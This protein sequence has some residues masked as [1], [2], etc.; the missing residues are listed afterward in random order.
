[1]STSLTALTMNPY[2]PDQPQV[3]IESQQRCLKSMSNMKFN[4]AQA[5]AERKQT[6]NLLV[7]SVNRFISF[8]I[9]AREGKF[10]QANKILGKRF[11]LLG[12]K[13]PRF[14]KDTFRKP[15]RDDFANLWLEYSYGWRP[16]AGDIHGAAELLAQTYSVEF[17]RP[18]RS[19]GTSRAESAWTT[20]HDD[21]GLTG[22]GRLKASVTA[23]TVIYYDVESQVA[24]VLK[25][26]GISNPALLA[27]E[28]LPY[29][30][31]LDWFI[32][33]GSYLEACNASAGLRFIKGSTSTLGKGS[34]LASSV[35]DNSQ[36]ILH[37]G[38]PAWLEWAELT[39]ERLTAFPSAQLPSL[40]LGL[41]LSQVTSG[42][43]LLNQLFRK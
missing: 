19:V 20:R 42:L 28:L 16:L 17:P 36:Y 11:Q 2:G 23:K 24:D 35:S 6:A 3:A 7:K 15:T 9:L 34:G 10:S 4:S 38:F 32:P 27:W 30:F 22:R 26:T 21:S 41:N 37:S 13:S 18:S 12:E 39:R 8:A 1:M 33:V 25:S 5:F 14:K 40:S 29:S 31:V 43:A